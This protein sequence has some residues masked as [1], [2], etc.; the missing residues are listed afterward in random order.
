[1]LAI[2]SSLRHK[3]YLGIAWLALS[4]LLI[5]TTITSD[6]A[7]NP[8]WKTGSFDAL[9]RHN[10]PSSPL[11]SPSGLK[12]QTLP[13]EGIESYEKPP[14]FRIVGLVFYGRREYVRILDCYLQASSTDHWD[15][16]CRWLTTTLAESGSKW[17][18]AR[19]GYFR[20]SD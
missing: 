19:R 15:N 4:W 14:G 17:R 6:I 7:A 5:T 10:A 8:A 11:R 20:G 3:I 13:G 2:H 12:K 1:M 18:N 16:A 9:V